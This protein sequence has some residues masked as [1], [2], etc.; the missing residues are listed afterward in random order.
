MKKRR[1][2]VLPQ[3]VPVQEPSSVVFTQDSKGLAVLSKEPDAFLTIFYFDKLDT[4]ILGRVSNASQK[5]LS[6]EHIS[7]NLNDSGLVAVCG[8]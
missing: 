2:L 5:G 7:C 8:I 3:E 1:T 6:A 4:I